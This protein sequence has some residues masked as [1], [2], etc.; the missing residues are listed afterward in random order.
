MTNVSSIMTDRDFDY[1]FNKLNKAVDKCDNNALEW[2]MASTRS[3][4]KALSKKEI[5]ENTYMDR[6]QKITGLVA[7]F[8]YHCKCSSIYQAQIL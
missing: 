5:T 1:A 7:S 6:Q 4:E 8:Q 2:V 3:N